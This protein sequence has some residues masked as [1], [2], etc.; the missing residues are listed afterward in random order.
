M[1][2]TV[3]QKRANFVHFQISGHLE[4][5][6]ATDENTPAHFEVVDQKPSVVLESENSETNFEPHYMPRNLKFWALGRNQ[7]PS[8]VFSTFA[9]NSGELIEQLDLSQEFESLIN[10]NASL[11]T[12]EQSEKVAE[13]RKKLQLQA[14]EV[15]F[16]VHR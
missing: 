12:K 2:L 6:P 7:I 13:A 15:M 14:F 3:S 4:S 1:L 10:E 5:K 16:A 8:T 9:N 11:L